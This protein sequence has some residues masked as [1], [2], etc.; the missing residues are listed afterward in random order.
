M[1]ALTIRSEKDAYELLSKCINPDFDVADNVDISF[2]GWPTLE[3][4]V[5]GDKFKSTITPSIMTGFIE[6]QKAIY[7]SYALT[8]YNSTNVNRLTKEEKEQLELLVTVS[9]GSS[10]FDIDFQA[11]LEKF[12]DNVGN[13]LTRKDILVAV[14]SLGV[15]YFGESA[16]KNYL[17]ER[18]EIRLAEVKSEEQ[19]E[20]FKHLRFASEE[21]TKRAKIMQELALQSVQVQNVQSQAHDAQ[22]ELVKS[23]R[24]TDEASFGTVAVDGETATELTKNAR[25]KSLDVRL[26]GSY[27]VL[28]VDSSEVGVFKIRVRDVENKEEFTAIVQDESMDNKHKKLIQAAEWTKTPVNLVINAKDLDGEIKQAIVISA[29]AYENNPVQ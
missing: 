14:L 17:E 2:D 22:T 7:K 28:L 4:R 16:Y 9:E 19:A 13:K 25:K 3:I 8:K 24:K 1:I 23:F 6:F 15:L 20:A 5:K 21:E 11:A 29:S 26:D 18:K 10:V 27:R 12:M